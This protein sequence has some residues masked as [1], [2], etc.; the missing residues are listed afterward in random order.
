MQS[1][2]PSPPRSSRTIS[3]SSTPSGRTEIA[4]LR[5]ELGG[6]LQG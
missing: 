2:P 3:V 4:T 5:S 6:V 1:R